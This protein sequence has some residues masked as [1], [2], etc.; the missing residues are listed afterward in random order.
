MPGLSDLRQSRTAALG[1]KVGC[2]ANLLRWSLT[3]FLKFELNFLRAAQDTV[4]ASV[5][6]LVGRHRELPIGKLHT[7][8][9]ERHAAAW[10]LVT[11]LKLCGDPSGFRL[12][13]KSASAS[14]V[15]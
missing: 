8:C 2:P 14:G 7:K 1:R 6:L 9:L 4:P 10:L 11:C 12:L 15:K 13:A 3:P 5:R